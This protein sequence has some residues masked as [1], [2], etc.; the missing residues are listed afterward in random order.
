M[1]EVLAQ[2]GELIPGHDD[3]GCFQL[4]YSERIIGFG[5]CTGCAILAGFLAIVSLFIL[6]LRKF[7]VLFTVSTLLFVIALGLL[8]GFARLLRS[9]TDGRRLV[10]A[11]G[12]AG[13]MFVTLFFGLFKK[14]ILLAIAGFLVETVSFLY[15][16]LSFFPGGERLFHLLLF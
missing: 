4:S 6:N 14:S 11:G 7:A 10:S 2:A 12:L 13:G 3:T 1:A 15:F 5:I 9:C 16:A 8:I